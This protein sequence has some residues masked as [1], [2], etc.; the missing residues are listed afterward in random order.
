M[1]ERTT[2]QAVEAAD[3]RLI[4]WRRQL[5]RPS[6]ENPQSTSTVL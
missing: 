1:C 3:Q 6:V 2:K 4:C 5:L